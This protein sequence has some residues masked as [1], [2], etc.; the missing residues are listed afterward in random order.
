MRR[1]SCAGTATSSAVAG[2]LGACTARPA[3]DPPEHQG[4]LI[5]R[6]ARENPE[7]GDR[8]IHGE[9]AGLGL[10]GSGI[11]S[12]RTLPAGRNRARAAP[13]RACL[14][15]VPALPGR[16]D[17]GMRLLHG[18]PAR[19]HPSL[20]PGRDRARRRAHPHPRSHPASNRG[21]D[22]PAGRQ[23]DHGPRRLGAP[24]QVHDPQPRPG[25]HGGIRRALADAGIRTVLCNVRV[26]RMNAIAERWVGGCC[27]GFLNRALVWNRAH[28]RR[29]PAR[30]R[31]PP[32]SAPAAPLP[33]RRRAAEAAGRTC[34]S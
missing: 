10:K 14:V 26:P 28:L 6:L 23:P 33:A 22:R 21:I 32:R 13:I 34:R 15:A 19:R 9:L 2:P 4:A 8:R 16:R 29:I 17:P 3:G 31:D 27:R 25:L 7:W 1:R 20:C 30:V 5:L 24:G 12:A 11:D 18:Q